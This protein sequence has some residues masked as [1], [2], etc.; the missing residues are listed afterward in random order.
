MPSGV[1]SVATCITLKFINLIVIS[2]TIIYLLSRWM[3]ILYTF[4]NQR[5]LFSLL[6]KLDLDYNTVGPGQGPVV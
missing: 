5:S 4:S 3:P 1:Y 6:Q 2:C